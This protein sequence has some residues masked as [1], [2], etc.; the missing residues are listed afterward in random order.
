MKKRTFYIL[1][2]SLLIAC[3]LGSYVAGVRTGKFHNLVAPDDPFDEEV[4]SKVLN[5]VFLPLTEAEM[6]LVRV[7]RFRRD[8]A[9]HW[10]DE[11]YLFIE[12]SEGGDYSFSLFGIEREGVLKI[13]RDVG[14]SFD[15]YYDLFTHDGIATRVEVHRQFGHSEAER[16]AIEVM[17]YEAESDRYRMGTVLDKRVEQAGTGQPAT[18]RESTSEGSDEPQPESEGR[19]R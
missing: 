7:P 9:G 17:F 13:D 16:D 4:P 19:S 1:G 3:Y 18:R 14:E 6:R 5:G 8:L 11:E 15:R 12:I 2:P 10:G